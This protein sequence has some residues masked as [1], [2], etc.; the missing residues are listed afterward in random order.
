MWRFAHIFLQCG[1]SHIFS[2]NVAIRIYFPT[3]WRFAHIFL[4]C[5]D[6][7]EIGL[8]SRSLVGEEFPPVLTLGCEGNT[9]QPAE[10]SLVTAST[11]LARSSVWWP[12]GQLVVPSLP[13][14]GG[15]CG[16]PARVTQSHRMG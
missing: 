14:V 13:A 6:L 12:H 3:M 5:G 9:H 16:W 8:S 10:W 11:L 15:V 2:Y 4:Q 1:D 7:T